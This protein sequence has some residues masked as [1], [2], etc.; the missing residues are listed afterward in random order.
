MNPY[1]SP[2]TPPDKAPA[3]VTRV[4]QG[5]ALV[6]VLILTPLAVFLAGFI[7][8]IAFNRTIDPIGMR[9]GI[10]GAL[11]LGSLV[12]FAPPLGALAVMLIWARRIH[13]REQKLVEREKDTDNG[14][15]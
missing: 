7:S 6:T 8:C 12:C 13:L 15:R 9:W 11:L 2:T 4:K 1:Q 10:S 3:S 5:F 14:R